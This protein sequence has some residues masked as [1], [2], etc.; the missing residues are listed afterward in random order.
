MQK[1]KSKGEVKLLW[2]SLECALPQKVIPRTVSSG[3]DLLKTLNLI[4]S[5]AEKTPGS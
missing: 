1:K 3:G 5:G 4:G 2:A